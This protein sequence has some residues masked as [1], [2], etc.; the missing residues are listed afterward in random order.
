MKIKFNLKKSII[1]ELILVILLASYFIY[2][3]V[4]VDSIDAFL[5][6][7]EKDYIKWVDF[8]VSSSAMEDAYLYDV[9]SQTEEM[10]LNWIELLAYLGAKYGG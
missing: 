5:P 9:E 8:N 1:C 2:Q 3:N 6:T 10:K 7:A 4:M